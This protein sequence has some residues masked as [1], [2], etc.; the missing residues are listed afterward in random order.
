MAARAVSRLCLAAAA[1]LVVPASDGAD[2]G[3]AAPPSASGPGMAGPAALPQQPEA[4]AASARVVLL[5]NAGFEEDVP[6]GGDPPGWVTGQHAGDLSYTFTIDEKERHAGKRSVRIDNIGTQPFGAMYQLVPVG[7]VAGR[8]VRFTA[9][10]KAEGTGDRRS[11]SGVALQ[12]QGKQ[13]GAPVAFNPLQQDVVRGTFGWTERTSEL[14]IPA[15]GVDRVEVG[16][17]LVGPGRMWVDDVKL[18]IVAP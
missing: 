1:W 4:R 9:W 16:V 12:V 17:M 2:G 14:A 3:A 18:E 8:K 6:S 7:Q 15:T 13:G 5:Q 10:V 11:F